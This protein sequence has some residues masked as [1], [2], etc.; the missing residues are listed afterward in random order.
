[1]NTINFAAHM[2]VPAHR[3]H[4]ISDRIGEKLEPLLPGRRSSWEE[5]QRITDYS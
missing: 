3:R 2:S 4:D 5:L 1:M